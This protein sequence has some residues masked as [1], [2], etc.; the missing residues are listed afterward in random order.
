[1]AQCPRCRTVRRSESPRFHG[2]CCQAC[3]VVVVLGSALPELVSVEPGG[4]L[5]DTSQVEHLPRNM[6]LE[7][8]Y[9]RCTS[10][11]AT[12]LV[13]SLRFKGGRCSDCSGLVEQGLAPPESASTEDPRE[14]ALLGASS[15]SHSS[16][17]VPS[18][19][20]FCV[21]PLS[22]RVR[23]AQPGGDGGHPV[24]RPCDAQCPAQS[25][26]FPAEPAARCLQATA[27]PTDSAVTLKPVRHSLANSASLPAAVTRRKRAW[28]IHPVGP[29]PPPG[30]M[31]R[32][33]RLL[34]SSESS[35][36]C[37]TVWDALKSAC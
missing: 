17:P 13:T 9:A 5:P 7:A 19:A 28:P 22:A 8:G 35:W 36:T 18:G 31:G 23:P 12:D 29:R 26:A 11:N 34:F 14:P 37:W 15:S 6:C 10:C 2:G 32:M 16:A 4:G 24:N 1:M 33:C 27:N 25:Q 20:A 3:G 21:S 30:A